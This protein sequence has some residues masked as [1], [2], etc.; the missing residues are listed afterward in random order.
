MIMRKF[1]KELFCRH[2]WKQVDSEYL[3]DGRH[4]YATIRGVSY[5][6]DYK[7]YA[8]NQVCIKCGKDRVVEAEEMII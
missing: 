6:S 7:Y 1:L 5:Y 2:V 3:R 4:S 8:L